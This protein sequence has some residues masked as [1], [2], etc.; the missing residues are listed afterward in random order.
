MRGLHTPAPPHVDAAAQNTD[1]EYVGVC[2]G[3]AR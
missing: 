2:E 1:A 3:Q